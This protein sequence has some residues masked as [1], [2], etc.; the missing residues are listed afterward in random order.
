MYVMHSCDNPPCVNPAHLRLG[1]PKENSLDASQKGRLS[2]KSKGRPG[3]A[4]H[5]AKLTE[6]DVIAIRAEYQRLTVGRSRM[7][8][9]ATRR[10]VEHYGVGKDIICSIASGKTWTHI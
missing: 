4:H 5:K 3:S 6:S 10:L 2:I 8:K 9:G 7:P 1:T